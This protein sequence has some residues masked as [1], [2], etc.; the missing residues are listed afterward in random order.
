MGNLLRIA[1]CLQVVF[2]HGASLFGQYVND[3]GDVNISLIINE[4]QALELGSP[5]QDS[6]VNQVLLSL[7]QDT[8]SHPK[9]LID[10]AKRG[11]VNLTI[12][13]LAMRV[14]DFYFLNPESNKPRKKVYDIYTDTISQE[15]KA[16]EIEWRLMLDR[17]DTL[18]SK[19]K[20]ITEDEGQTDNSRKWSMMILAEMARSDA[21]LV[22]Y[23]FEDI[24]SLRLASD[25]ELDYGNPNVPGFTRSAMVALYTSDW[26]SWGLDEHIINYSFLSYLIRYWGDPTWVLENITSSGEEFLEMRAFNYLSSSYNKPWLLFEF[27]QANAKD[28]D[29]VILKAIGD[30]MIKMKE[31]YHANPENKEK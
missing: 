4:L 14:G 28:P 9:L 8:K 5:A 26:Q 20:I 18:V 12:R 19:L 11:Q 1:L 16:L 3:H 29:T 30:Q 27:M 24:N 2:L 7:R 6:G 17:L 23:F 31:V 22:R 15:V 10:E 25:Y 21:S 13:N